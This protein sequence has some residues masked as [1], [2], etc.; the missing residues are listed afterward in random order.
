MQH[1]DDHGPHAGRTYAG[2]VKGGNQ[3]LDEVAG[4][5]LMNGSASHSGLYRIS[6]SLEPIHAT[7]DDW[8]MSL[9]VH[10]HGACRVLAGTRLKL[11]S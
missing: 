2:L 4:D 5:S 11:V 10:G 6:Q 3:H 9:L 7:W 1:A 8:D